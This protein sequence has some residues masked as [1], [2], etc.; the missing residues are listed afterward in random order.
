M[1]WKDFKKRT[2]NGKELVIAVCQDYENGMVA[3]VAFQDEEAFKETQKTGEMYFYST[4]KKKLWKKGEQSGN[5]MLLKETFVDCD[6]DAILYKVELTGGACH[7]GYQTCF[8]KTL[9][10]KTVGEMVF[11]PNQLY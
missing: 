1:D 2:L 8:H 5:V 11:D 6:G 7:E 4:S 9:D 3:M 10:G